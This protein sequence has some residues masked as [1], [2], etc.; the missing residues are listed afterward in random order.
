LEAFEEWSWTI[1]VNEPKVRLAVGA[2]AALNR[3]LVLESGVFMGV[4]VSGSREHVSFE[5]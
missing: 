3:L 5:F 4:G 2:D 1:V